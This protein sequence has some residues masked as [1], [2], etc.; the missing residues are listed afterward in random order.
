MQAMQWLVKKRC[1]KGDAGHDSLGLDLDRA[2]CEAIRCPNGGKSTSKIPDLHTG[3][4]LAEHLKT[5]RDRI[6]AIGS[7][8]FVKSWSDSARREKNDGVFVRNDFF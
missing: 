2:I 8:F 1:V 4:R 5:A 3:E 6:A 7:I